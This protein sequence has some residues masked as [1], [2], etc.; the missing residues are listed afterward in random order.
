VCFAL[1][2]THESSGKQSAAVELVLASGDGL[3][4]AC[5]R[6]RGDPARGAG[7]AAGPRV[8]HLPTS[9]QVY[10]CTSACDIRKGFDGLHALAKRPK[11]RSFSGIRHST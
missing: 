2:E 10:L 8:I 7:R 9:V 4:I 1:V 3:Q 5:G 11:L 6:R